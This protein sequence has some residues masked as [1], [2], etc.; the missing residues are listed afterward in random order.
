MH[1][2]RQ[3][4][5][6]VFFNISLHFGKSTHLWLSSLFIALF[7]SASSSP[8]TCPLGLLCSPSRNDGLCVQIDETFTPSNSQFPSSLPFYFY[9]LSPPS[10]LL[11]LIVIIWMGLLTS[12]LLWCISISPSV[13]ATVVCLLPIPSLEHLW[14]TSCQHTRAALR[15]LIAQE[16]GTAFSYGLYVS[17]Y[18]W[19]K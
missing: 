4:K 9:T 17:T 15:L 2:C 13:T 5:K 8:P 18:S 1:A 10:H 16:H 12:F 6:C 11:C 14:S 3:L 7:S 19:G